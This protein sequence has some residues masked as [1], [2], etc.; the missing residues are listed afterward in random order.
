VKLNSYLNF[1][2]QCEAAFRF[3]ERC[4]GGAIV[5]LMNHEESPIEL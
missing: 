1:V 2:G 5:T 4:L 3:Y